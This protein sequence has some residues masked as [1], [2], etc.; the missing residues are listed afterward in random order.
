MVFES[1]YK[2]DT[3]A[4]ICTHLAACGF[5]RSV[6]RHG[7]APPLRSIGSWASAERVAEARCER[8]RALQRIQRRLDPRA[9]R[10]RLAGIG[11]EQSVQRLESP[12][13]Q[14]EDAAGALEQ[15]LSFVGDALRLSF[16]LAWICEARPAPFP[17]VR[18][19]DL[20]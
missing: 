8:T 11:V 14:V 16:G 4:G 20:P 10:A 7:A 12:P 17:W 13:G 5:V 19:R 3:D 1:G 6:R 15:Q 2:R 9:S 18:A